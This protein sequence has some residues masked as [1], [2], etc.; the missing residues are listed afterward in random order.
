MTE[1]L[2]GRQCVREALAAGRRSFRALL[3]AEGLKPAPILQDITR[4]AADRG[5]P[6]RRVDRRELDRVSTRHQGVA[7][8]VGDYPYVDFEEALGGLAGRRE[9]LVLAPDLLQDPQNLGSLLRSAEAA[10]VDL[11]LIQERR[12]VGVTPAVS[13]ASAGAAEH[14]KVATVVNLRRALQ[15]MQGAG[16]FV[17]GLERTPTSLPYHQA[18][19]TGRVVLVV[20][21]EGEG[22]RRL[23]RE[24]CDV[25]IELPM[26]GRVTSLN[27]A[28][29]GAI[30][31]FEA[32]RQRSVE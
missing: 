2:Y 25:L 16:F 24:T 32:L 9:S 23:T 28:V 22:L 7:L 20:G 1:L 31:L 26:R 17:H 14:L 11:V 4:L 21:S 18:D 29:A 19:L 6:L 10:G 5:V 3:L 8:E 30:V 27:A 12:Q 13:H 15:Q